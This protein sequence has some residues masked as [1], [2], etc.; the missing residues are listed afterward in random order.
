MSIRPAIKGDD[1]QTDKRILPFFS[2]SVILK[3]ISDKKK[4]KNLSLLNP[5]KR[6]IYKII[7]LNKKLEKLV[8][9]IKK[10]NL[11]LNSFKG[12]KLDFILF[13]RNNLYFNLK[14][15]FSNILYKIDLI[16]TVYNRNIN[17]INTDN[18]NNNNINTDNYISKINNN[19]NNN[20]NSINNNNFKFSTLEILEKIIAEAEIKKKAKK[21]LKKI[22]IKKHRKIYINNIKINKNTDVAFKKVAILI[23]MIR[24]AFP[25]INY[26]QSLSLIR[27]A[28]QTHLQKTKKNSLLPKA[29]K[30]RF[31]SKGRLQLPLD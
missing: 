27:R 17:N 9:S 24:E 25:N 21:N 26:K 22:N 16:K 1:G 19:I 30:I 13:L 14:I 11:N 12:S 31:I 10:Y 3:K 2:V 4:Y 18:I 29:N 6:L 20:K 5:Q 23:N 15:R 8:E 28:S 7:K